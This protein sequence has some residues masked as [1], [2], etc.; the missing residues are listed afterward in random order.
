MTRAATLLVGVLVLLA[1][2][3]AHGWVG[4]DGNTTSPHPVWQSLPVS[5]YLNNSGSVDL[6]GFAPTEAVMLASFASWS[7]P[8]CT[9]WAT[10][11][12]GG[13]TRMPG[14]DSVNVLGWTESGWGYEDY[15]IGVTSV[16]F[17]SSDRIAEADIDFNGQYFTWSTSGGS[18]STVDT[19]S[20]ATHEMGHFLGLGDLYGSAC[21]GAPTM[22]GTY[23]GGTEPRTISSD[24]INGVCTLYPS[25]SSGCVTSSD[26]PAGYDCVGG[27]C[28][29]AST[30]GELCDPC[31]THEDC[32]STYDFCL[33]GFPDGNAYCGQE[34]AATSDCPT[35]Y[36]CLDVGDSTVRQC[37]PD[38][39]DC[40]NNPECATSADC[41]AGYVCDGGTCVPE[42]VPEC[43]TS[44][45]CPAGYICDGG[46][47]VPDPSPHLPMCSLCTSHEECGGPSDLCMGG[48]VDGTSRCGVACE[49]VGGDCGDGN[50]CF[51][52][53]DLPDQCVPAT[54]DCTPDCST[55]AECPTGEHCE[56]GYCTSFC[57]PRGGSSCPAGYYCRFTSCTTG[58]C[59]PAPAG[60]GPLPV[61]ERCA[62]D[63]DCQTLWCREMVD[64]S[65]CTSL[66]TFVP[67]GVCPA[68]MSCQPQDGGLCGY[69]S[70]SAGRLG[71]ACRADED[72]Q[73]G[74]C[75]EEYGVGLCVQ[76]CT[77]PGLGCTAGYACTP[78]G[79]MVGRSLCI[80]VRAGIGQSC[81]AN[82][83]CLDGL[84]T[85]FSGRQF[86]TRTCSQLGCT[87]P[88]GFECLA[89]TEQG[90]SICVA[91][92]TVSSGCGCEM[93]AGAGSS[94][95]KTL[96]LISA[97]LA[98]LALAIR[99]RSP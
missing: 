24:D 66:C 34:C 67:G 65:Y 30:A 39:F 36:S 25:G 82:E 97:V 10:S 68:P 7:A 58:V 22:C 63:M 96:V 80:P 35:G 29:P 62:S 11:Y 88:S 43:T 44:A 98:A 12:Q 1:P 60:P 19:Q 94:P 53:P 91:S 78:M 31:T 33:S 86:C 84:C 15:A 40:I 55:D 46:T 27:A 92:P 54:M 32:G 2:M 99:R 16:S 73:T 74:V 52:F 20:I 3:L 37:V 4:I 8:T 64:G 48:F 59:D 17:W 72:C 47:C 23:S 6:G 57:D 9:D 76:D 49:N 56:G 42:T 85:S 71:D 41:P 28:V 89:T 26:C 87:C 18:G 79:T 38:D 51:D 77:D 83:E 69:C 13:T 61:G 21:T 50:V 95:G 93:L 70:C 14:S 81:S 75:G 45:D 5:Y 90:T